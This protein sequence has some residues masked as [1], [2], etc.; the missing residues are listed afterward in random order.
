MSRNAGLGP[1]N[2]A[3]SC[4]SSAFNRSMAA[5]SSVI[6]AAKLASW[7]ESGLMEHLSPVR[8][9]VA[10]GG[11]GCFPA[12]QVNRQGECFV[13]FGPGSALVCGWHAFHRQ[14]QVGP[15]V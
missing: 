13:Q 14:V 1:A 5:T 15:P 8:D 4:E 3:T 2:E 9:L 7:D 10:E 12:N 6:T 11:S